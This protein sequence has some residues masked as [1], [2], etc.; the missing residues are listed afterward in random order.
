MISYTELDGEWGQVTVIV[1]VAFSV[2][3]RVLKKVLWSLA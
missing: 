3:L 2:V 1:G